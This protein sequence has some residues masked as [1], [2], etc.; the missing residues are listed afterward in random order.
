VHKKSLPIT[1][2]RSSLTGA[3]LYE[4]APLLLV[5]LFGPTDCRAKEIPGKRCSL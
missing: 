4:D 1:A 2:A 3:E 5:A